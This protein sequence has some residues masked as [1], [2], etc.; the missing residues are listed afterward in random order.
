ME[1]KVFNTQTKRGHSKPIG[2]AR[3]SSGAHP[4]EDGLMSKLFKTYTGYHYQCSA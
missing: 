2:L 1:H 3:P 4:E